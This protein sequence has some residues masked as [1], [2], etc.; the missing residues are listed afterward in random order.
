MFAMIE[1]L[2]A[3][4]LS[5]ALFLAILKSAVMVVPFRIKRYLTNWNTCIVL[6]VIF[7]SKVNKKIT[8]RNVHMGWRQIIEDKM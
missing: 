4:T 1:C 5:I 7:L 3:I 8:F 6:F 2:P